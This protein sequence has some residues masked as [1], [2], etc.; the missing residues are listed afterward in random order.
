M[1]PTLGLAAL[2]AATGMFITY[3]RM[4]SRINYWQDGLADMPSIGK[5]TI[6]M[7][8]L[9]EAE[10]VEATIASLRNQNILAVYPEYFELVVVDS[11]SED[12]TADLA[13]ALADRVITTG[14]GKLTAI[15]TALNQL[16]SD[17]IVGVDAD[18]I[19]GVNF[20]N[21]ML[22][23]FEDPE[24]VGVSGVELVDK[25]GVFFLFTMINEYYYYK[26]APRMMGRGVAYRREAY[27]E[28]GGFDLSVDQTNV[29]TM[30]QEEEY[31]FY[32]HLSALGKVL[33]D[34]RASVL[35]TERR[36]NCATNPDSLYCQQIAAKERF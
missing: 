2:S 10:T 36:L 12:G 32:R 18:S 29:I 31:G 7:P 16:D 23:H 24:V 14:C 11:E 35:V 17:V 1:L 15:D 19:Y 6:L 33:R 13:A 9:N 25:P 8:T 3:A 28:S 34:Y 21:L 30:M 22:K 20:L 5:V 26:I 4:T 27:F